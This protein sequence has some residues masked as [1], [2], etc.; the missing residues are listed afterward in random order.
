MYACLFCERK[1]C[2]CQTCVSRDTP[3]VENEP[4]KYE[5][6]H[7]KD[8]RKYEIKTDNMK[9]CQLLSLITTGTSIP[10]HC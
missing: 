9:V 10:P 5:E 1:D 8:G 6:R 4:Q 3:R 7:Q 2:L